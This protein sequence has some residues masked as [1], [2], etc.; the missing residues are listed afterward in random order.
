MRLN[1]DRISTNKLVNIVGQYLY[2]HID[3]AYKSVKSSNTYDVYMKVYYQLPRGQQVPGRESEGYNDMHEMTINISLTTYQN[4]I[5]VNIHEVTPEEWTFGYI[6]VTPEKLQD[7][8]NSKKLIYDKVCS[9][10]AKH[11]D[12]YNFLF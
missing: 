6:L 9:K 10:I 5:R 12:G 2:R 8:Q 7:V 11:Y 3:G 4:K 1:M